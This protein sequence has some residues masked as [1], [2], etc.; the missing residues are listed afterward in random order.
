MMHGKV[1]AEGEK[2]KGSRFSFTVRLKLQQSQQENKKEVSIRRWKSANSMNNIAAE[3]DL[4]YEFGSN[5]NIRELRKYFEKLNI[6]IDMDAWQ[7]AEGFASILK[8]LTSG[9]SKELKRA[10]FKMEMSIRKA[11]S[12]KAKENIRSVK[13]MLKVEIDL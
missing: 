13:E 11:D 2:G 9:G 1:W 3:Q 12:E 7:K 4:M 10:V 6:S 5:I 8:Q